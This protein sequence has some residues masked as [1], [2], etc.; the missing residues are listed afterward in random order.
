MNNMSAMN[1]I[2]RRPSASAR[3]PVKGEASKAKNDVDDVMSDLSSVM[4]GRWESE[5][6][7]DIRVE[8]ITPV[9]EVSV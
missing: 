7:M 8:D 2:V 5:E 1:I 3:T 6:F 4:R 9:L